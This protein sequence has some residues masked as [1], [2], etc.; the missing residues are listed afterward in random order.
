MKNGKRGSINGI[1]IM[2]LVISVL[3]SIFSTSILSE[4]SES[5]TKTDV[6]E[7]ES[8]EVLASVDFSGT[9]GVFNSGGDST[10]LFD[11]TDPKVCTD[12]LTAKEVKGIEKTYSVVFRAKTAGIGQREQAVFSLRFDDTDKSSFYKG[13]F[14]G[15]PGK[16]NAPTSAGV[17]S[18]TFYHKCQNE[19]KVLSLLSANP[20]T[21]VRSSNEKTSGI[22]DD[23]WHTV[24]IVQDTDNIKFYVDGK[25]YYQPDTAVRMSYPLSQIFGT[26]EDGKFTAYIDYFNCTQTLAS[27]SKFKGSMDYYQFYK[28]ALTA[29][30]VAAISQK[31]AD[32]TV[33]IDGR[34]PEVAPKTVTVEAFTADEF[35][36][37]RTEK[38]K[39]GRYTQAPLKT[40]CIF[41]GW[42]LDSA[43]KNAV[44]KSSTQLSQKEVYAKFIPKHV[45]DTKAQV[46]ANL[47]DNDFENDNKGAIR[48]SSTVDSGY[49]GKVGFH[50]Q[51]LDE[52]ENTVYNGYERESNQVYRKMYLVNG[53]G[54]SGIDQQT[55]KQSFVSASEYFFSYSFYDLKRLQ[56]YDVVIKVKAFWETLDGTVVYG[57]E[58]TKRVNQGRTKSWVFLSENANQVEAYGNMVTPYTTWKEAITA[59]TASANGV[60]CVLDN[61]EVQSSDVCSTYSGNEHVT[62]TSYKGD[63]VSATSRKKLKF[64]GETLYTS[65][66]S[67][68][69]ESFK[70]INLKGKTTFSG[71]TLDIPT[72]T[73]VYANGYELKVDKDVTTTNPVQVYGGKHRTDPRK[74]TK[75]TLLGGNYSSVYGGSYR[76]GVTG[77]TYVKVAGNAN[78]NMTF[79]T[80][81]TMSVGIYGGSYGSNI[82]GN[83]EV[84]VG[85]NVNQSL[86]LKHVSKYK[87][88]GAEVFGGCHTRGIV[89][90]DT[91]VT[92]EDNAKVTLVGG[93]GNGKDIETLNGCTLVL[94]NTNVTV[95]G[96][97]NEGLDT[98]LSE[99]YV[100]LYGG[101]RYGAVGGGNSSL[102]DLS[103]T[104]SAAIT[105][106][107]ATENGKTPRFNYIYGGGVY[108]RSNYDNAITH[109]YIVDTNVTIDAWDND[110]RVCRAVY[111]G[112]EKYLNQGDGQIRDTSV[113]IKGGKMLE[114]IGGSE[115]VEESKNGETDDVTAIT[116]NTDLK[117]LGGKITGRVHGGCDNDREYPKNASAIWGTHSVVGGVS[118]LF[119]E[120]EAILSFTETVNAGKSKDNHYIIAGSCCKND[121]E[122]SVL[123]CNRDTYDSCVG[124]LGN[125][126]T[127]TAPYK[128]IVDVMGDGEASFDINTKNVVIKPDDV[129]AVTKVNGTQLTNIRS[130][131]TYTYSL[132]P[133]K[134]QVSFNSIESSGWKLRG[135]PE[136]KGKATQLSEVYDCGS[137]IN[138]FGTSASAKMQWVYNIKYDE[139][140][141]YATKVLETF[142]YKK[143]RVSDTSVYPNRFLRYTKGM[144]TVYINHFGESHKAMI[145]LDPNANLK[146]SDASYT[147]YTAA[148]DGTAYY[149]YGMTKTG[150][151]NGGT[152]Q[153]LVIRSADNKLIIV[154]G[155]GWNNQME[156][157]YEKFLA[158]LRN[159]TGK[160]DGEKIDVSAW[161]ITHFHD[162]HVQGMTHLLTGEFRN[163]F[164]IERV[165]SNMPKLE[166]VAAVDKYSSINRDCTAVYN[167]IKDISYK[168]NAFMDVKVHTGDVIQLADVKL[169]F[170]YTHE[171]SVDQSG[172]AQIEGDFNDTGTIF[173]V[174]SEG[175]KMLVTGDASTKSETAMFANYP[176]KLRSQTFQC[177]IVQT[178][179]HCLNLMNI[180]YSYADPE[181]LF[182][183]QS[184]ESIIK[185]VGGIGSFRDCYEDT[186]GKCNHEKE[187][188]DDLT[189]GVKYNSTTKKVERSYLED[190]TRSEEAG[191]LLSEMQ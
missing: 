116:G 181:I 41:G 138:D 75:I 165:I 15:I 83:T 149:M 74:D 14:I 67:T 150:M 25:L 54:N 63:T 163:N 23:A 185:S 28:G 57:E 56:D 114:V 85:G 108:E 55:P 5:E 100:M 176:E 101:A 78:K 172:I 50:F 39:K 173:M 154:D 3:L 68:T 66:A 7:L 174:E 99:K 109:N 188:F 62:V 44:D 31:S 95:K 171:D 29:G 139:V 51:F 105:V 89:K 4:A 22:I 77:S 59:A 122:E 129:S 8:A 18:E 152:G 131:N 107:V 12:P 125:Y 81:G 19:G 2:L 48:F 38:D 27:K 135:I 87:Y 151:G 119:I 177:N 93:G 106:T 164:N 42:Y 84:I 124:K 157:D 112:S 9:K 137:I 79:A 184:A 189:V 142:G 183:T 20:V 175:M 88:G 96:N 46:S 40:G 133:E 190:E 178:P 113:V 143:E 43:C 64:A 186:V 140:T 90:G 47:L 102:S 118:S 179:H 146:A 168:N 104:T 159:I 45:L 158:F 121:S 72:N 35:A 70:G 117:L 34:M 98:S 147:T 86:D 182:F 170:L 111:G 166:N 162:D 127:D 144:K 141:D 136:C 126:V 30:E 33:G 10:T 13:L 11:L 187:Y 65:T 145:I 73:H 49:Y 1:W 156:L 110:T 148:G 128:Y 180:L 36:A 37:Y 92:I 169:R 161:V 120:P 130:D 58:T 103:E 94:G 97:V 6:I 52:E 115:I 17:G 16:Y 191:S 123:I 76:G 80:D 153:T 167:Q 82:A 134:M 155:G 132:T 69:A 160:K 91:S 71:I 26:V 60:V 61:Y 21:I 32:V 24:A 53:D